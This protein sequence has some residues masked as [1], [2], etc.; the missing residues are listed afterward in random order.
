MRDCRLTI[1]LFAARRSR[2][3]DDDDEFVVPD[4][5]EDDA[6]SRSSRVSKRSSCISLLSDDD[7]EQENARTQ[8]PKKSLGTAARPSLKKAHA[9]SG[10]G[11]ASTNNFLT[12]A[13]KRAQATKDEKKSQEDPFS[14]LA[15]VRDVIHLTFR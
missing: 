9:A 13:E 3:S 4:D 15:D 14:F 11:N 1:V 8:K 5:S 2:A 6:A 10:S 7:D 12:A